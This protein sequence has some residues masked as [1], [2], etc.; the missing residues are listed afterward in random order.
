[1]ETFISVSTANSTLKQLTTNVVNQRRNSRGCGT[2]QTSVTILF[3][4]KGL[5]LCLQETCNRTREKTSKTSSENNGA[6]RHELFLDSTPTQIIH[7]VRRGMWLRWQDPGLCACP[8][9]RTLTENGNKL[10]L[11]AE[12]TGES[13]RT[14]V[15]PRDRCLS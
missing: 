7:K 15:L 10:F 2:G 11:D 5:L 12:T 14:I 8:C 6:S 3:S 13:I 4:G 9:K 1:M